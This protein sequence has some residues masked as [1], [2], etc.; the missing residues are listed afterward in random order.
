MLFNAPKIDF[1]A[2]YSA[3]KMLEFNSLFESSIA[4]VSN[5]GCTACRGGPDAEESAGGNKIVL[6]RHGVFCRHFGSTVVTSDVNQVSFFSVSSSYRVSHPADCGDRG[7][8]LSVSQK[9]LNDVIREF[10][11][12]IDEHPTEPFPFSSGPC[13]TRT[14]YQHHELVAALENLPV[15]SQCSLW[16]DEKIMILVEEV[17][18]GAYQHYSPSPTRRRPMTRKKH[19]E[20]VESAK[21]FVAGHF[22][23]SLTLDE[24]ADAVETSPFH[25]SR[26]FRAQ[27]G[28]PVYRYLRHLR[29]RT[30]LEMLAA[31]ADDLTTLAL[32]LGFSSHSHFSDSFRSEFGLSPSE[33]RE[34]LTRKLVGEMSKNLEVGSLD[35]R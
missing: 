30:S 24:I 20:L 3:G 9:V 29:L 33:V 28:T 1:A 35:L 15:H 7:T 13:S 10:E 12:S 22:A 31:G 14:F 27:T 21:S 8:V 11:P 18:R 19:A 17:L 34:N 2:I 26:I 32:D 5:Y 25:L 23:E 4:S 16:V 6:M